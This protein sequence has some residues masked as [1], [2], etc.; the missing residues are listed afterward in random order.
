M[1]F[2]RVGQAGRRCVCPIGEASI[3]LL[4][5]PRRRVSQPCVE[6][7]RDRACPGIAKSAQVVERHAAAQDEHPFVAQRG[8]RAP[9]GEVLL[10]VESGLERQLHGRH[11]RVGVR[12]LERNEGAVIE[13]ALGVRRRLEPRGT[14]ELLHP[15]REPRVPRR[16]PGDLVG[17]R[18][19]AVIVIKNGGP[20]GRH[21]GGYRLLPVG[22]DDQ[23]SSRGPVRQRPQRTQVPGKLVDVALAEADIDERPRAAAVR[24]KNDRHALGASSRLRPVGRR[25]GTA[26]TD[27]RQRR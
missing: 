23:Q 17:L 4:F 27:D 21:H 10:G 6:R 13:A 18:R 15:R 22:G 12:E 20:L 16:R 1:F 14:Q 26:A 19:K 7:L 3:A 11:V 24:K 25:V 9:D 8:E 2:A 5:V